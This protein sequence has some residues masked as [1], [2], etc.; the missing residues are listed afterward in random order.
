MIVGALLLA[1]AGDVVSGSKA[2]DD[3]LIAEDLFTLSRHEML[4]RDSPS[5]ALSRA[6]EMISGRY[7]ELGLQPAPD[8]EE[9][10]APFVPSEP[11]EGAT[12]TQP[13]LFLR[14]FTRG[15]EAPVPE[16]CSF[17]YTL[18]GAAEPARGVMGQDWVPVLGC[19]GRLEGEL[20]FAG[21]GIQSSSDR[22]D[23]FAASKGLEGKVAVIIGGEPRHKR[24]FDGLEQSKHAS[25]WSK[26]QALKDA[27]VSGV[28]VVRRDAAPP[29]G[30]RPDF[31][32]LPLD[33]RYTHASFPQVSEPRPPRRRPPVVEVT[34]EFAELLTGV[35]ILDVASKVD[36]SGAPKKVSVNPCSVDVRSSLR[37][38]DVRIDNVVA[39]L[40]G[41]D[42]ELAQEYIVIGAHYD[43]IGVDSGGRVGPG[44]DDNASGTSGLLAVAGALKISKP[45]RSV[46]LC[47]FSAEE[48]GLLGSKAF[49]RELPVPEGSVIAMINMD[50]IGRGEAGEVA[51]LGT[52]R[53]PALL[54]VLK[55]ANKLGKTGIRDL[56]TGKGEEL[57]QRSDHYS[58]HQ[59]GIPSLFFF[60]G[61]PISR[62]AV[63][64]T[65]RDLADL[66]DPKKI[67]N[68]CKLV[69][70]T[71][72]ILANDASRPPSPS[73]RR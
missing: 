28:I 62:N 66:V 19:A 70:Q 63:Y 14:P 50:M 40:P 31:E 33:Y 46:I 51:V 45:K 10:L 11:Q 21:F 34:P 6:A 47:A 60:E 16:E 15:L 53:N 56:V 4:G 69:H 5:A 61:L 64:H 36:R 24:K 52:K 49:C 3:R 58:F 67:E 29:K 65:W 37:L 1:L 2:I 9:R 26:L 44:A 72:W 48:D 73:S 20:A 7:A 42:D 13:N 35:D 41:S 30:K 38:Q 39:V 27:G 54:D 18:D 71:A 17:T 25:L 43:H 59:V 55:R 12:A 57:W 68:T 32:P 8:A 23:D 22:Y